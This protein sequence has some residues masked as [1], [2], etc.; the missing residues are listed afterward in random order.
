MSNAL[1]FEPTCSAGRE[2]RGGWMLRT[3]WWTF[4]LHKGGEQLCSMEPVNKSNIAPTHKYQC[5]GL[6]GVPGTLPTSYITPE[7][8]G[9]SSLA[10]QVTGSSPTTAQWITHSTSTW[11]ARSAITSVAM[12]TGPGDRRFKLNL[13]RPFVPLLRIINYQRRRPTEADASFWES[14]NIQRFGQMRKFNLRHS[15]STLIDSWC[16]AKKF[17]RRSEMWQ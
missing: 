7:E 4:G 11:C 16:L 14:D 9:R 2:W 13:W 15:A 6:W 8:Q 12:V 3:R 1:S 17:Q 10:M 5:S